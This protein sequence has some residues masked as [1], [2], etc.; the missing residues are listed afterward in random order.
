MSADLQPGNRCE[1]GS[2]GWSEMYAKQTAWSA[3]LVLLAWCTHARAQT[4]DE[5]PVPP[6]PDAP[7]GTFLIGAA[8]ASDEGFI[9][10]AAAEQSDLFG[11][12][13]YLGMHTRISALHRSSVLRVATA[14]RDDGL[15]L[16]G[17]LYATR[18]TRPGFVRQAFG[19][20]LLFERR[21]GTNVRAY[22]GYRLE[23]VDVEPDYAV[24]ARTTTPGL[25]L[26]GGTL[27]ALRSGVEYSTL[28]APF[29]PQ[30][31]TRAGIELEMAHPSIGSD[32]ELARIRGWASHHRPLGPFILHLG[33][34][35]T[36]VT[37]PGVVPLSERLF[38]DSDRELRGYQPMMFGPIDA[39]GRPV[40]GTVKIVGRAEL[41][42]PLSRK[43]GISAL[44]FVDS[45][46]LFADR[47]AHVGTSA[48]V[49]LQWRSPLG[50]IRVSWAC[51]LDG[52]RC[53]LSFGLGTA[54]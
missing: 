49:G 5:T 39:L 2:V 50:A 8:L 34:A 13:A 42:V 43:L 40:G 30:R 54:F 51:P 22:A 1:I 45:G 12:G 19:A 33:G 4:S 46:G 20:S 23:R 44:G 24:V 11:T 16:T 15:R 9:A 18:L 3:A 31:G 29:L 26:G 10:H 17:E 32:L 7:S 6:P 47:Q 35:L 53:A 37:S 27:S 52:G 21:L 38:L 28:D 14:E 41:E 48:G 36:S 25:P